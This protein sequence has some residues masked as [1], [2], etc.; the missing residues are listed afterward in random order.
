MHHL[1]CPQKQQNEVVSVPFSRLKLTAGIRNPTRQI[2]TKTSTSPYVHELTIAAEA[3]ER[4]YA[5]RAGG[6]VWQEELVHRNVN[7]VT[8][9]LPQETPHPH[10][11]ESVAAERP[12]QSFTRVLVTSIK[13]SCVA[14]LSLSPQPAPPFATNQQSSAVPH[15][16]DARQLGSGWRQT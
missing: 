4:R 6:E 1:L 8:T 13:V 10:L 16:A 11:T 12:A 14:A 7:D 9:L 15:P 5:L 2:V 3:L